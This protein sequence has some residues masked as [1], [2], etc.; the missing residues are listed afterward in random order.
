MYYFFLDTKKVYPKSTRKTAV[1]LCLKIACGI[2]S[3]VYTPHRV[4]SA[5][6]LA[7]DVADRELHEYIYPADRAD[8]ESSE[9]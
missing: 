5:R 2:R 1:K 4:L 6:G 9:I 7:Y 8:Y 3:A